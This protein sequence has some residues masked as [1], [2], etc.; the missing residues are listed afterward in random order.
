MFLKD[1]FGL[2]MLYVSFDKFPLSKLYSCIITHDTQQTC[3]TT[4]QAITIYCN[5]SGITQH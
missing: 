5:T 1:I 3:V 2:Y 4:V